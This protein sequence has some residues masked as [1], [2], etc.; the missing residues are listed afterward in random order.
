MTEAEWLVLDAV[1]ELYSDGH[2]A[3]RLSR[4]RAALF[5]AACA[6]AT[7]GADRQRRLLGA[8]ET[9]EWAAD[10][11]EWAQV[12]EY[13]HAAEAACGKV[14]QGSPA[15]LWALA[16]ARLAGEGVARDWPDVP[17]YLLRAAAPGAAAA[18][19]RTYLGLLRDV[20]GNPFRPVTADP[21]WLTSTVRTLAAG[22]YADRAFDRLP[23]LADAL[24]D[25]GCE[26]AD[27]LDHCHAGGPHVR[28][29]WVV[30]LLLG[31]E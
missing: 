18:L 1:P 28:G 12:A 2:A 25:A 7:P 6:R 4:R 13:R 5:A 29:C 11:G 14:R 21:A 15:H 24:Q 19:R 26:A 22:I 17:A 27:I 10:T 20:A 23:I 8:A 9:A 16:A 3:V 31:K 30:D